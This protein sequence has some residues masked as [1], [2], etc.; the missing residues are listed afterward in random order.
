MNKKIV[1]VALSLVLVFAFTGCKG[2][3]V[4]GN[5]AITSF[6]AVLTAIPDKITFDE[7]NNGWAI[8]S[9]AGD[10]FVLGKDF[11]AAGKPDLLI[12]FDAKPFVNAGLDISKLPTDIYLYDSTMDKILIYSE[13]GNK[14]FEYNG[15]ATA[16]DSFKEIIENHR[17]IVGYH[18]KLDHYGVS[19]GNGNMFEWAK[20]MATNDKDIVFVLNPQPFI[21]AGVDPTKIE[22]WVFAKVEIMDEK[23][24]PIEVDKLLK[25]FNLK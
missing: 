9:P 6:D 20:D 14:K 7:V 4:V 22:G 23:G 25:P 12:D 8:E 2:T 1:L 16:L 24:K 3:D 5:A 19:L 13:I 18:E 17:D 21:D 11:S 15:D 10:R